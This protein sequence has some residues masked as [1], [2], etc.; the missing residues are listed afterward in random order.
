[1]S[2]VWNPQ[3]ASTPGAGFTMSG[4]TAYVGVKSGKRPVPGGQ[5]T[6][7]G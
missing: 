6:G 4:V 5:S 1:M 3:L 2:E 7:F